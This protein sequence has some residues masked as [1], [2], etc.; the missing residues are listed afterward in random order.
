MTKDYIIDLETFDNRPDALVVDMSVVVFD[1]D[2][3]V[4]QT[5]D[6]LVKSGKRFKLNM[7]SQIGK[8]TTLPSTMNFWKQQSEAATANLKPSDEDLTVEQAIEGVLK[9]LK[10]SGISEW[11]SQGWCRGMSFDFPIFES[12][13]RQAKGVDDTEGLSPIKF[14]NQRDIRT[15][16]ECYLMQ[17]GISM[18]PLRTGVLDG[19]VHHDSV[20]DCAKDVIMLK[21]A[22]RYMLG[23]ETIPSP[24][25]V[26]PQTIKVRKKK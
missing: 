12:M 23:L 13:L 15:A 26:D 9:Y 3:N 16:I 18:T 11:K 25:D 14:W 24:E 4:V 22:Q 7:K 21:T 2:P 19:F 10:D 1:S 6:E 5:F 17:R 20:H 8:R